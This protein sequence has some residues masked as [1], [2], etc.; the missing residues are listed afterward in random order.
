MWVRVSPRGGAPAFAAVAGD[1]FAENADKKGHALFL[2][3]P[4]SLR[5]EYKLSI[6]GELAREGESSD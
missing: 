4:E 1:A 5:R 3:I 6:I 2:A